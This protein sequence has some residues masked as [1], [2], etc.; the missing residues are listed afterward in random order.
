MTA[1]VPSIQLEDARLLCAP[2]GFRLDGG[3]GGSEPLWAHELVREAACRAAAVSAVCAYSI[4]TR[5]PANVRLI[6]VGWRSGENFLAA[7]VQARFSFQYALAAA[8]LMA[9]ERIDLVHHV[10]PFSPDQSINLTLPL[11]GKRAFVVGPVQGAAY[12]KHFEQI[13]LGGVDT[14]QD[15][16]TKPPFSN[17]IA[18]MVA[19]LLRTF[20][21]AIF[22]RA[23]AVVAISQESA[24]VIAAM[25]D[26]AKI[27][28]IPPGVD[29]KAFALRTSRV[30]TTIELL[31]A[32]YLLKR[33]RI[34]V[35]LRALRRLLDAQYPVRLTVAGDGP[36][37]EALL[38]LAHEL[39][40][41]P[42]VRWIGFV[43]NREMPRVYAEAD[44]FV[45]ASEHEGLATVY[46]ETLACGIPLVATSN[47]GSRAVI[48]NEV[49]G[50]LVAQYD[51]AALAQAVQA[52]AP[53]RA[54]IERR[55][56]RVRDGVAEAYD[57]S[58]VGARYARVYDDALARAATR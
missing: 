4:A 36:E 35:V 6:E 12:Q 21:H 45:S 24:A 26:R 3:E 53:D 43:P 46:L 32:G 20:N 1:L 48:T 57:W 42:A 15:A 56:D 5:L 34:D 58:S 8:R 49:R 23:D 13:S 55:R 39:R 2:A 22:R 14:K 50:R 17:R 41:G 11:L 31:T 54:T 40:L 52:V 33:K 47:P 28:V 25:C 27:V 51:D 44:V 9:R 7:S 30:Q 29:T 18:G 37:R 19:P 16:S 38:A 10:L